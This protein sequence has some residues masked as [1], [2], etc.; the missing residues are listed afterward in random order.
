MIWSPLQTRRV[1]AALVTLHRWFGL[2]A[3]TF[4]FIA[5]TTGALIAWDHELDAWLNPHW[6]RA[7][8]HAQPMP[9][10]DL[11]DQ[12]E[13]ADP[14]VQVR[15]MPLSIETGHTLLVAVQPSVNPATGKPHPLDFDQVA[16][17]PSTGQ[18]LGQRMWGQ[19]SLAPEHLMPFLYKLHSTMHLPAI[20]GLELD[21]WFMGMI[22]MVWVVD[23]LI[24]MWIAFPNWQQWRRSFTFRWST[25]GHRLVFDLHRSGGV[26][27][28]LLVLMLAVTSVSMNLNEQ[29]MRPMVSWFSNVQPS[30][31]A[32]AKLNQAHD[33]TPP[34]QQPPSRRD[35]VALA[36]MQAQQR[37]WSQPLG[38]IFHHERAGVWGV[39]FFEAGT[40]H[41]D[42]GLGHPW[43]YFDARNG[44]LLK[45]LEPGT[46]SAGDVFLQAMFP[47]H[48][49]RIIGLPGRILM[50]VM[51][52]LI[53]GLSLTGVLIWARKRK[54]QRHRQ[55][56]LVHLARQ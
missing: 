20:G 14:R 45:A 11:A 13:R 55:H 41:G 21:V 49:G 46:G 24:A 35:I 50:S 6:F 22:A 9:P 37:N 1:R 33:P 34:S 27:L 16:L 39:G 28:F 53:A 51:G 5:G 38:A 47:L 15:W 2:F 44:R 8:S 17:D 52:I 48:S 36:Q 32:L 18:V 31:F 29:I 10:L 4:L 7:T 42:G 25:G 40:G 19:I 3:A 54:A 26:W 43:L 56:S 30:P 12:V 23:T